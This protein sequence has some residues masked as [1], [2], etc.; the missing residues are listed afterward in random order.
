MSPEIVRLSRIDPEIREEQRRAGKALYGK[1]VDIWAMG[2]LVF[3]LL[4]GVSLFGTEGRKDDDVEESILSERREDD[5]PLVNRAGGAVSQEAVR[6]M[7]ACLVRD[8]D[9]RPTA[10][11]MLQAE[12]ISKCSG[13]DLS[14]AGDSA[15]SGVGAA[16]PAAAGMRSA[17][18]DAALQAAVA[19]VVG[20]EKEGPR[21]AQPVAIPVPAS[22]ASAAAARE[23]HGG[24]G[25]GVPAR[26]ARIS[27]GARLEAS[28]EARVGGGAG[29][30]Q[31]AA[32]A[33]ATPAGG[34]GS[35][36]SPGPGLAPASRNRLP[37][38]A[39]LQVAS[40]DGKLKR[41]ANMGGGAGST[42]HSPSGFSSGLITG[43]AAGVEFS[44]RSSIETFLSRLQHGSAYGSPP[45][46][47][48]GG[49]ANGGLPP[50]RSS[51]RGGSEARQAEWRE[52]DAPAVTGS[53]VAASRGNSGILQM[54]FGGRRPGGG[55][56]SVSGRQNS[57][58]DA[59]GPSSM[60]RGG[61]GGRNSVPITG[62]SLH[63]A[64]STSGRATDPTATRSL[65]ALPQ[66]VSL[67]LASQ[68]SLGAPTIAVAWAQVRTG[69]APPP[70][71]SPAG[72]KHASMPRRGSGRDFAFG[73]LAPARS[74][75]DSVRRSSNGPWGRTNAV[76]PVDENG[77]PSDSSRC[78]SSAGGAPSA[79]GTAHLSLPGR[80]PS[81]STSRRGSNRTSSGAPT[82]ATPGSHPLREEIIGGSERTPG[83]SKGAAAPRRR[84]SL[85]SKVGHFVTRI[86]SPGV[87]AAQEVTV[88]A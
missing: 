58:G 3:E 50:Q 71:G 87:S 23:E 43:S 80:E 60:H 55:V 17:K 51:T 13:L 9:E 67:P 46:A 41:S 34:G 62:G 35:P 33:V 12:W 38:G 69:G 39:N 7:R 76:T 52:V 86:F 19:A 29:L 81:W 54:F 32:P 28:E 83:K 57:G 88:E 14:P 42:V 78:A 72:S 70:E 77:V 22:A 11:E 53:V 26:V 66:A 48:G 63:V 64:P 31:P 84:R 45:S 18:A 65:A 4:Y 85:L 1:G 24:G 20:K 21:R 73:A 75:G 59:E 6:F 82:A 79:A 36:P 61:A 56:S 44:R 16:T 49:G 30:Q 74:L 5:I 27:L 10:E 47:R 8:D 37:S 25:G 68:D 40:G 15:Y 2:V